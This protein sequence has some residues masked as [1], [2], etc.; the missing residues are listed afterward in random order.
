MNMEKTF[1]LNQ[2]GLISILNGIKKFSKTIKVTYGPNP[3]NVIFRKDGYIFS[4]KN[5]E[6]IAGEIFFEDRFENMAVK[7][8]NEAAKKTKSDLKIGF[9]TTI[10]LIEAFY[11]ACLKYISFG[12]SPVYLKESLEKVLKVSIDFLE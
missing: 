10:I 8:I 12:V 4:S 6:K 1:Q 5:A 2:S 9:S 7:I 3:K 11:E